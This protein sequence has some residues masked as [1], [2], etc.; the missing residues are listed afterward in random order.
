MVKDLGRE[1]ATLVAEDVEWPIVSWILE[2]IF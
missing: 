1:T 2:L